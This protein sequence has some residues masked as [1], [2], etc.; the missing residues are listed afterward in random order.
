MKKEVRTLRAHRL[1]ILNWFRTK[2]ATFRGIVE[3]FNNKAKLKI[4][5]AYGFRSF[6]TMGIALFHTFGVLAEPEGAHR[7]C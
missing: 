3:G 6:H 5:K 1:L 7:F 4:R 2:G